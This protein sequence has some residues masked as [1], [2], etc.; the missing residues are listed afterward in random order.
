MVH[1]K[2]NARA[3]AARAEAVALAVAREDQQ[4]H[5][6]GRRDHLALDAP[7]PRLQVR[8]HPQPRQGLGQQFPGGCRGD[9]GQRLAIGGAAVRAAQQ[10]AARRLHDALGLRIGNVQ[11]RD[12]GARGQVRGGRRDGG[13]PAVLDDPDERAHS[14]HTCRHNHRSTVAVTRAAGTL[15][16][17]SR[18]KTPSWTSVSCARRARRQSS[19]ASEPA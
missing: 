6:F 5:P 2:A 3:E 18:R 4:V 7:A 17:P 14:D 13:L 10:R 12:L 1:D 11:Q 8:R 15:S 16:A 9:R 19:V